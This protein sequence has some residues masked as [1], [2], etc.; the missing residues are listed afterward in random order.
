VKLQID[1]AGV[2]VTMDFTLFATATSIPI[3]PEKV[4]VLPAG[5]GL[6]TLATISVKLATTV[7]TVKMLLRV[8]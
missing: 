4:D 5:K 1:V 3:V 7:L 8:I 6:G 2:I